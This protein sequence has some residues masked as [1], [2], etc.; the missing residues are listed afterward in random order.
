MHFRGQHHKGTK[1]SAETYP[2][3]SFPNLFSGDTSGLLTD[4]AL[5]HTPSLPQL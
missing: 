2:D 5:I 4:S 1:P 3:F